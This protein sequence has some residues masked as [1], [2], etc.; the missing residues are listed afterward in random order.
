MDTQARG[1][2]AERETDDGDVLIYDPSNDEA[3]IRSDTA[4]PINWQT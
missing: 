2:F 3:W 1:S 4:M